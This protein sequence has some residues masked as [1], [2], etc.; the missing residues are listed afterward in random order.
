MGPVTP[1]DWQAMGA[2]MGLL[3][4]ALTAAWIIMNDNGPYDDGDF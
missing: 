3:I 2:L 4:L 1:E